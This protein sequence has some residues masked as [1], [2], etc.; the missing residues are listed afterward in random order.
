MLLRRRL[1]FHIEFPTPNE[2]ER[3]RLWRSM[4]PATAPIAGA[5]D[6]GNLALRYKMSGG[7]IKNA[8]VRAAYLAARSPE[9]ALSQ[10]L[11]EHAARLEW[12]EMGKLL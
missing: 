2:D 12:E 1:R 8:V 9:R 7:Y 3:E 5:I 10:V 4:I 11:L 6:F